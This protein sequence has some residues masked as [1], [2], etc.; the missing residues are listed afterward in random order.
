MFFYN[1]QVKRCNLGFPTFFIYFFMVLV[2]SAMILKKLL[3]NCEN[4]YLLLGHVENF[5]LKKDVDTRF[6]VMYKI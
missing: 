3:I 2:K 1:Y 4:R 6:V 5:S